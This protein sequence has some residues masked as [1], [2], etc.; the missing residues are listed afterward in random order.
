MK[1]IILLIA[2]LTLSESRMLG[3]AQDIQP[4]PKTSN[5]LY[6]EV[7]TL[8]F[9]G[10]ASVNY[11]RMINEQMSI[12]GGLGVGYTFIP[13]EGG[14]HGYG[15]TFMFNYF[16]VGVEYRLELGVGV[17]AMY[18]IPT[19]GRINLKPFPFYFPFPGGERDDLRLTPHWWVG[20][21][22]SIGYRYQPENG[23]FFFRAGA[24]L[25]NLFGF[26]F[27]VS[28]GHVW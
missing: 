9:V 23:G 5:I 26:P 21:A 6:G 24:T 15:P 18:S 3:Q 17:A 12:R 10:W 25:T 7:S 1:T 4:L 27:Q 20:P 2:M 28:F 22:I 19:P 14:C 16:P 13:A 8:L 11:E